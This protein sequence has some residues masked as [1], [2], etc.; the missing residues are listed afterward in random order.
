MDLI[1]ATE[2]ALVAVARRGRAVEVAV[3]T[4]LRNAERL[5]IGTLMLRL[6]RGDD[7]VS[8]GEEEVVLPNLR[9]TAL[10][11]VIDSGHVLRVSWT[12]TFNTP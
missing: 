4:A 5:A 1:A 7:L 3:R 11:V 2:K 12:V 8:N 6:R 9:T 10:D